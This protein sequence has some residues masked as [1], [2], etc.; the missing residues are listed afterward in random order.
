M[1]QRIAT[2]N[3]AR[4]VWETDQAAICGHLEPFS[5]T[6][7]TSGM[8][9]NGVAYALPTWAPHTADSGS[10]SLPL[11]EI[12]RIQDAYAAGLVDGEGCLHLTTSGR[13]RSAWTAKVTINMAVGAK[14][15]LEAMRET[16][17]GGLCLNR[18]RTETHQEVWLWSLTAKD[19]LT[20]FL[21]A[22]RP[23]LMVKHQQADIL[24]EFL[25]ALVLAPKNPNGSVKWDAAMR[26]RGAETKAK[27]TTLNARGAAA[28]ALLP[29]PVTKNLENRQSAQYGPN[30]GTVARLLKT[31][32]AQ[33]A[34]NGGSQHPDKRRAGGHGPTL[35]DEIE[36]L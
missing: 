33:L 22:V 2:W 16:Y 30:L 4:S 14:P 20:A 6:W 12:Q 29:T 27:I 32:T 17:G 9:R 1:G 7:P 31:P 3:P 35:A 36:H 26:A 15:V 25:G 24:L 18:Q 21:T 34:I 19:E 5:Q 10:S 23:Y 28:N 8:T 13:N 11:V